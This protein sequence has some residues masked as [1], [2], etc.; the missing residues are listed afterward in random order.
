MSSVVPQPPGRPSLASR[1]PSR[2]IILPDLP[3][4]SGWKE[5]FCVREETPWQLAAAF[6][7]I[8]PFRLD[9]FT[10]AGKIAREGSDFN[11]GGGGGRGAG[12]S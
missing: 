12:L 11:G 10:P 9:Y 6:A 7:M 2:K 3:D 5:T 1:D 8:L 4:L